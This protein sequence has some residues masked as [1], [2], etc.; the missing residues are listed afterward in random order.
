MASANINA[1]L[2]YSILDAA[3]YQILRLCI[4]QQA[5]ANASDELSYQCLVNDV[6]F[7]RVIAQHY[8]AAKKSLMM[9]NVANPLNAL[10]QKNSSQ[11]QKSSHGLDFGNT[12]DTEPNPM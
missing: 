11:V 12:K 10:E 5:R 8:I 9:Q 3:D 4:E 7:Q 6:N 1:E 2:D